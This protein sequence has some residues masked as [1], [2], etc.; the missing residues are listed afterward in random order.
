MKCFAADKAFQ[1]LGIS[2]QF[3]IAAFASSYLVGQ[4]FGSIIFPTLTENFGR[5]KIYIYSTMAYALANVV[6]A[7]GGSHHVSAVIIG[8]GLS[9]LLSAIPAVVAAGSIEDMFSPRARIMPVQFWVGF[10]ILALSHGP[11]A[12]F[13]INE[14]LGW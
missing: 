7:A 1:E 8:R 9:G 3:A 11:L 4:A 2:R 10:A 6:V 12:A 13:Y 5:R 14:W